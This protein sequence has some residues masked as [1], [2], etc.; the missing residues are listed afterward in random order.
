MP[1]KRVVK[2]KPR[3]PTILHCSRCNYVTRKGI[4]GIRLHY[5]KKHPKARSRKKK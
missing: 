5:L 1:K 2:R 4:A 3:V